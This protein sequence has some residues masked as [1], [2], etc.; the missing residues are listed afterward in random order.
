MIILPF[1][2][3][4]MIIEP[5]GAIVVAKQSMPHVLCAIM[6]SDDERLH[7][8][9]SN[10]GDSAHPRRSSRR[11]DVGGDAAGIGVGE[12]DAWVLFMVGLVR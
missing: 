4:S 6:S 9:I 8:N 7:E 3:I 1:Q 5:K 2:I 10:R 12:Y 11:H